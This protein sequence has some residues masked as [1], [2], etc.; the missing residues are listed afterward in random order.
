M[1]LG[2]KLRKA[3][4]EAQ[5]SQRQLSEGLITRNMLSQIENGSAKPS[6]KTLAALAQ[7]LGKN[8]SFFLEETAVV[9][10]N[11]AVMEAARERFDAGDYAAAAAALEEFREPDLVYHREMQLINTLAHL[12]LA[13]LALE[14]GREPYARDLLEKA[15]VETAYCREELN[16]RRLLLLGRIP[17]QSVL[18]GLPS[19]DE[20]L[21][22]R[23]EAALA[24]KQHDR[25][26]AMLEAAQDHTQARW[27]MLRGEVHA[28]KKQYLQA[29]KCFHGA[30]PVYPVQAAQK[31]EICY[32]ELGDY[33]QAY[34]YAR[35]NRK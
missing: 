20:E 13:R 18:S 33:R 11:Q 3:R 5:I 7:R 23:A 35:K 25:A 26:Q 28:A 16:R 24:E 9:S 2:E 14:E 1:E 12:E 21:L 19:L 10:P 15:E 4:Q 34:N 31:L 22:L 17:G 8:V 6:M 32:R 29:A 27:L 30:E